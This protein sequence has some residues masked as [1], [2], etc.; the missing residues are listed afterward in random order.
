MSLGKTNPNAL[1]CHRSIA[2]VSNKNLLNIC[3]IY[4]HMSL[5]AT[6]SQEK[7]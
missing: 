2:I 3:I 1:K 7:Q 5:N 6:E 4:V